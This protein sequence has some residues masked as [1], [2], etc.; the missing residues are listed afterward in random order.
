MRSLVLS[1]ALLVAGLTAMEPTATADDSPPGG[2]SAGGPSPD[3]AWGS[4]DGLPHSASA[5]ETTA[6]ADATGEPPGRAP[7]QLPLD[8]GETAPTGLGDTQGEV[9]PVDPD[10]L[11]SL[12]AEEPTG[13]DEETSVELPEERDEQSRTFLNTDGTYTTR[14]YNEPV[15]YDIGADGWA[16]I[17][18]TLARASTGEA[19]STEST[20][21]PIA[22]AARADEQPL[23]RM[24]LDAGHAVGYALDGAAPVP[25]TVDG[26]LITYRGVGPDADIEFIGGNDSVKET[27]VLNSP[28]APSEWRFP[29][30]LTGLTAVQDE[31]GGIAFVDPEEQAHAYMP[32]GWMEDAATDERSGD[33][34]ISGGV[35]YALG[36]DTSG[37]QVLTVTLDEEWLTAPERVFPVRVDPSVTRVEASSS[38]YVQRPYNVNFSTDTVLKVGTYDG[39]PHAAAAFLR[40][41]GV[42]S[43]LRN[44]WVLDARLAIYNTWS[45]SCTAKPVAV[46]PIT[47]NWSAGTLEDYPGPSTGA[48]LAT[49]SF[50]HGWRPN[51]SVPWNCGPAWETIPLGGNGRQLVDDWTHGRKKNYGLALTASTSDSGGWKQFGSTRYPNG[52]PS[53]DVTWT[54]YERRSDCRRDGR[55]WTEASETDPAHG[56]RAV[57][58]ETCLDQAYLAANGGSRTTEKIRPPGYQWATRFAGYMGLNP[59]DAINNCHLIGKDLGGSGTDLRNLVTCSRQANYSVSGLGHVPDHMFSFESDI[60]DAVKEDGQVVHYVVTPR[61]AGERTVPVSIELLARGVYEDGSPGIYI[62]TI[63]PNSLWSSGKGWRNLGLVNDHKTGVPVPTGATR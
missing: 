43:S 7:D 45:Y 41:S 16:P 63:V 1:V 51:G 38:T 37:M 23:V 10:A 30:H 5:D 15:N 22:F 28:E 18:P 6:D 62:H 55:G 60:S 33:G 12:P 36:E 21:A 47:Q 50:A 17:D 46:R 4:A 44:A 24:E 54:K 34:A 32:T 56:N 59:P 27:L 48:A 52:T 57:G 29:L 2:T 11:E 3:Q 20:E 19:W 13:F 39:G 14:Y 42:E 49:D 25:G 35:A 26:P 58:M 8:V 40:F 53:L 61:Y 9:E 31:T